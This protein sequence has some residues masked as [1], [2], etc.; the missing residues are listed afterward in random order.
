MI[1]SL[2]PRLVA[3]RITRRTPPITP[4]RPES[5]TVVLPTVDRVMPGGSLVVAALLKLS[6]ATCATPA[7]PS[8]GTSA[9]AKSATHKRSRSARRRASCT[10]RRAPLPCP[11]CRTSNG[12]GTPCGRTPV[13]DSDI[14]VGASTRRLYASRTDF[15]NLKWSGVRR[16]ERKRALYTTAKRTRTMCSPKTQP[17]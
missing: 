12:T 13:C 15:V 14:P 10:P 5:V 11:P 3:V 6:M 4:E 1:E 8:A 9:S 16:S 17:V 2:A 7:A